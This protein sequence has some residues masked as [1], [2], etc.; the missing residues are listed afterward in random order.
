[1]FGLRLT[2]VHGWYKN[3]NVEVVVIHVTDI[4]TINVEVVVIDIT[5]INVEV[6]VIDLTD[7]PLLENRA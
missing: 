2:G 6:V 5:T 4:T 3:I 1:M 7:N